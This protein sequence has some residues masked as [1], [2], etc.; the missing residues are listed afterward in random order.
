MVNL[1]G[2]KLNQIKNGNLNHHKFLATAHRASFER[3]A[4]LGRGFFLNSARPTGVRTIHR[5]VLAVN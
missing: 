1:D 3:P 5:C 4:N 2:M